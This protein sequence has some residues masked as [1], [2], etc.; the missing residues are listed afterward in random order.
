M[1]KKTQVKFGET[2]G[3]IIIVYL[4]IMV[5][6]IWY[7]NYNTKSLNELR[8]N[9]LNDRAFE[10]FSYL[11]KLT[12]IHLTQEGIV[13]NEFDESSLIAMANMSQT[14]EG[15]EYF[16]KQLGKSTI[17]IEIFNSSNTNLTYYEKRI[18]LYNNTPNTQ[19]KIINQ[20]TYKSLIPVYDS[21]DKSIKI[22]YIQLTNYITDY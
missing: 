10:K 5:G 12:L 16:S 1:T 11:N 8:I 6:L 18:I 4:I 19:K 9:D 22:G 15:K 21:K 17:I 7:N 2:I 20:Q 14:K 13:N 3:I